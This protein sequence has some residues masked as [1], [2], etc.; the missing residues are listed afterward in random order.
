MWVQ[1][2]K[3]LVTRS[4]CVCV[5]VVFVCVSGLPPEMLTCPRSARYWQPRSQPHTVRV[6]GRT[7][8]RYDGSRWIGFRP[9]ANTLLADAGTHSHDLLLLLL[10]LVEIILA[11]SLHYIIHYQYRESILKLCNFRFLPIL[12]SKN[13]NSH[14][15]V[16][17]GWPTRGPP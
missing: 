12:K 15:C 8:L 9:P 11:T 1:V 6:G 4:V 14:D 2:S 16:N 3:I 7:R 13:K 10:Q 5:C 17:Q